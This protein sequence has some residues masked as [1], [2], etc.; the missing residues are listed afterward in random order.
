MVFVTGRGEGLRQLNV[1]L[2][3]LVA[4]LFAGE[5]RVGA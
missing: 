2:A 4:E 5:I 1:T 3:L